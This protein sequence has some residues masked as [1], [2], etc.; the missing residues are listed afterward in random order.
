MPLLLF[1]AFIA[2]PLVEL[3][4]IGQVADVI[5]LGWT[6]L[7]LV[8]DSLLGAVL[9]RNEGRRAWQAFRTAL[10]NARWPGDEVAQGALVLVGGALLL[11]PGFVTDVLG[12][13]LVAPP[14]RRV[15][16]KVLRVRLGGPVV[17]VDGLGSRWNQVRDRSD[18]AAGADPRAP[19]DGDAGDDDGPA[20]VDVEVLRVERDDPPA[21]G[22]A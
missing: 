10:S 12:L 17:V 18:A 9:V 6:I 8:A 13:L 2:V 19:R 3:F 14:S 22:R 15:L 16:S 7:L 20:T 11:T 5:G 4:V 21:V 1:V